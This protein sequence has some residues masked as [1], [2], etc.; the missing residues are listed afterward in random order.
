MN[1]RIKQLAELQGLTGPNYYMSSHELEAFAKLIIE[2]C[3]DK[4]EGYVE[5]TPEIMFLPL[6]ILEHF[7]MSDNG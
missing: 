3:L 7:D 1:E 4:I 5:T 2:V 6:D